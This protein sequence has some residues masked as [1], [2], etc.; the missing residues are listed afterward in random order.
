MIKSSKL[1]FLLILLVVVCLIGAGIS[2]PFYFGGASDADQADIKN[3]I[4]KFFSMRYE[5]LKSNEMLNFSSIAEIT[6]ES[7]D[8]ANEEQDKREIE[9]YIQKTWAIKIQ[10]YRFYLDYKSISVNQNIALVILIERNEVVYASNPL[11]PAASANIIHEISL[12]RTK[13]GWNIV[14]DQYTDDLKEL[15][16][17]LTKTEVLENI[18]DNFNGK[19]YTKPKLE[20]N[21]IITPMTT[22]LLDQIQW[23]FSSSYDRQIAKT[24]ADNYYNTEGPVPLDIRNSDAWISSWNQNYRRYTL[25]EGADCTNFVSQ[26]VFEATN[27]TASDKNYFYPDS[28]NHN[29]DWWFYKFSSP[30]GGSTP[31]IS[32]GY[33]HNFLIWNYYYYFEEYNPNWIYRGPV[34]YDYPTS[35]LCSAQVGDIV[36]MKDGT[37]W[38]HTVIID[39]IGPGSTCNGNNIYVAAHSEDWKQRPLSAYSGFTWYPVRIEG[40][41]DTY[42][43]FLSF[44]KMDE[45]SLAGDKVSDPYPSAE[46][47]N[48]QY[49]ESSNPYPK[50]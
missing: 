37:T 19:G 8:W 44:I 49:V 40:Y 5:T 17:T 4:Y 6:N 33:F 12:K 32:V 39:K 13:G 29:L 24:Y 34:G 23:Y 22:P 31:W 16:K 42:P 15:R 25:D 1:I 36:F 11:S 43:L 30:E 27:F 47:T 14:K 41:L 18:L 38:K 3:A 2:E 21:L 45:T 9:N 7:K 35:Q 46:Q 28:Y 10:D 26:A 50:P 48:V 20:P